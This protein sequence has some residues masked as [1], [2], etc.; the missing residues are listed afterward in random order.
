MAETNRASRVFALLYCVAVTTACEARSS[1]LQLEAR[2]AILAE[3][4]ELCSVFV[5]NTIPTEAKEARTRRLISYVDRVNPIHSNLM[6]TYFD[7]SNASGLTLSVPGTCAVGSEVLGKVR[8]HAAAM[9]LRA[10][11][12]FMPK[13][14]VLSDTGAESVHLTDIVRRLDGRN[15]SLAKCTMAVRLSPSESAEA[16]ARFNTALSKA[17]DG[18]GFPLLFSAQK[19]DVM[20][21]SLYRQCEDLDSAF[22]VLK[23][24]IT[25]DSANEIKM[26]SFVQAKDNDL[27]AIYGSVF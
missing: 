15:T 17:R 12:A 10:S 4:S 19:D 16:D 14:Q 23:S 13:V 21:V 25:K 24:I 18:Y 5:G 3:P 22:L 8:E 20:Y 26:L 9:G 11:A 7:V 6:V 1:Q 27:K 2:T